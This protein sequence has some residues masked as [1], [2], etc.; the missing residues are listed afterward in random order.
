MERWVRC[1]GFRFFYWV[2]GEMFWFWL[3]VFGIG[4]YCEF[5]VVECC[6]FVQNGSEELLDLNLGVLDVEILVVWDNFGS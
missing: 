4:L 6:R 3:F 2:L 5:L 1:F